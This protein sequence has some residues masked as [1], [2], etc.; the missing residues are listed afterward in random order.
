MLVLLMSSSQMSVVVEHRQSKLEPDEQYHSQDEH[1]ATDGLLQE[2][3]TVL[4]IKPCAIRE[5]S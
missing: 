5:T 1:K 2:A 3:F 4:H